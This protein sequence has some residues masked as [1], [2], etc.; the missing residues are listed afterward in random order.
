[1]INKKVVIILAGLFLAMFFANFVSAWPPFD[2][3]TNDVQVIKTTALDNHTIVMTWCDA[4]QNDI[5]FKVY[6][7][8]GTN[9]TGEIDADTSSGGCAVH[10]SQLSVSAFNE[11]TFVIG[12]FDVQDQDAT[13]HTYNR[14]GTE[15][16]S[17][18]IDVDTDVG[19]R[20][21]IS[22]SAF[23]ETAF[24]MSWRDTA[25]L[26]TGANISYG[27]YDIN[28]NTITPQT[29]IANEVGAYYTYTVSVSAFNET[30]FVVSWLNTSGATSPDL[31]F[32]TYDVAGNAIANNI[33]VTGSINGNSYS[34]GISAFNDTAFV[35]GWYD[36]SP[37]DVTFR[38]YDINGNAISSEIDADTAV[39]SVSGL[40]MSVSAIN[41]TAFAISWY[42][43]ID[44]DYTFALYDVNGNEL[45]SAI[46]AETSVTAT[47]QFAVGISSYQAATGIGLYNN[48]FIMGWG[49]SDSEAK[50]S[51]FKSKNGA[52]WNGDCLVDSPDILNAQVND[53]TK[54]QPNTI[55][56][57][58]AT[59][60]AGDNPLNTVWLEVIP[61]VSVPYNTT[62][63]NS[64]SEYFNDS[65]VLDE[66]GTWTFKFYVNDTSGNEAGPVIATDLAGNT[67]IETSTNI[68]F[69]SDDVDAMDAVALDNDIF[70]NAWCDETDNNVYFA[71]YYLNGSI[72]KSSTSAGSSSNCASYDSE[73]SITAL[74]STAFVVAWSDYSAK[75]ITF[76]AFDINGNSLYTEIDAHQD[77]GWYGG[78]SVSAF[79]ST[80]IV[81]GWFDNNLDDISFRT[82]T[83]NGTE[84][85]NQIDVDTDVGSAYSVSV[86]AF[87]S[88]TFVISWFDETDDDVTFAIY[89]INGNNLVA[90]IDADDGAGSSSRSVSVSAF[91]E[92]TFVIGWYARN[93]QDITF[94]I[95]DSSGNNLTDAIDA[96]TGVNYNSMGVSVSAINSTA[97]VISWFDGID[98]DYTFALY[99]VNGNELVSAIDA[100]ESVTA[101]TYFPQQVV[102]YQAATGIGLCQD[103]FVMG[104][105]TTDSAAYWQSYY[106]NG[107]IL[108][109]TFSCAD[110]TS[111][112][113]TINFPA[114][115]TYA[116]S[117]LPL[118]FNV[119]LSENGSV[120][121]SLNDG[122]NNFTMT[123]NEG[124]IFGTEFNATNS[125][126]ADGSYTFSVYANDT[127]GNRNYTESVTFSID[128]TPPEVTINL[129][130]ATTYNSS[131]ITFNITLNEAG[132][133]EYSLNA[134]TAN[135]TMT[136]N[137]NVDFNHTNSSIADGSYTMNAYCNDSI[138][139]T[140]YTETVAFNIDITPPAISNII[141][142]P[143]SS[144]DLD[145]NTILTFNATI[146]DPTS[147]VSA[148]FLQ[149]H[150][151]TSW[152]NATMTN[153]SAT[154]Y[155]TTITLI[156]V[157]ANY[158]FN[159]WAN[160]SLGNSNSSTNQTFTSVWDC[161][162]DII[163]S[164]GTNTLGSVSG[165]DINKYIGNVTLI[166]TGDSAYSNNNCSLVFRFSHD[167]ANDKIYFDG[168]NFNPSNTYTLAV[169]VNQTVVVNTSFSSPSS[170]TEESAIIK[171]DEYYDRSVT[172]EI[173]ITATIVTSQSGP[174]L[175]QEIISF[176]TTVYLTNGN[177]SLEGYLKNIMGDPLVI[178]ENNTAY[179]ATT[180]WEIP[181]GFTNI[182]GNLILN[183]TNISD[184]SPRYNNI[185]LSFS[186]LADATRGTK[187]FYLASYGYNISGAL[188][189]NAA[190]L[191]NLS[192]SINITFI[193]YNVS[194]SV[195]VTDCGSLD[196]D[197]VTPTT[198]VTTTTGGSGGGSGGRGASPEVVKSSADFQ[199]VRGEENEVTITFENK[200]L[201]MTLEDIEFSVEGDIAKYIQLVPKTLSALGPKGK[202]NILLKI[203]SPSYA[204]L[205]DNELVVAMKG[206]LG[207]RSYT[208]KKTIVL[209]IHE[210]SQQDAQELLDKTRKLIE[211][212]NLE[213]TCKNEVRCS[214]FLPAKTLETL[215]DLLSKSEKAMEIFDYETVRD[216]YIEIEK[217][218]SDAL[219]A[220][221]AISELATLIAQ[222]DERGIDVSGSGRILQL[223]IL[224]FQRGEFKQSLLR[225]KEAQT[226]YALEVKGEFGKLSYYLKNNKKE[227]SFVS[228]FLALLSFTTY[229]VTKL[230]MIKNKIKRLMREEKVLSEL[231]KVVQND[232]FKGKKMSME[233]YQESILQYEKRLSQVIESLIGLEIQRVYALGLTS[234]TKK[235]GKEKE[236]IIE[237]IKQVQKEYLQQGKIETRSYELRLNS[238]NRRL[239]EIDQKVA[240]LEAKNA[241]K[242]GKYF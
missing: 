33:K 232:T 4:T 211:S 64:G 111:P 165:Y 158:T 9:L 32:S 45:V 81:V 7:L 96:D 188:I 183:F 128:T 227:I 83:W 57:V 97:F 124:G 115:I 224:S 231:I 170:P 54:V 178:N 126:I 169:G 118:N 91:N 238:Y 70:V 106:P 219:E 172:S 198:T 73:V 17:A 48:N 161:T 145:P 44:G 153:S 50:W 23:N 217:T 241:I 132:Y 136:N 187:T 225:V 148:V 121:Y 38:T 202:F 99:D 47:G 105:A 56:K 102:S 86:S 5:S 21:G 49:S 14:D 131:S 42:D 210:L 8:N 228:I 107:T 103:N 204:K 220:S 62:L 135:V 214:P 196:G 68:K 207:T 193:C 206:L 163:A 171:L 16:T 85:S 140:N 109:P 100:E 90:A 63:E 11:T 51:G 184:N 138:G 40:P 190:G 101:V 234:Q 166:N 28:G 59:V 151:G 78:V 122:I 233:E 58:N 36:K 76:E 19:T 192:N 201:N 110:E 13:F 174:Y 41:S 133:C 213:L 176:P 147:S 160:D 208:D 189:E 6:D 34:I 162:W 26:D 55:V 137:G 212:Y 104:W 74:N 46:D 108:P 182:S 113:V 75:D 149:Y 173:N 2:F 152:V 180:F 222:A 157:N 146:N 116:S 141:Y 10:N 20:S 134:G 12:F 123:G 240:T 215:R 129:P 168:S 230:Q 52:L 92:T 112:T 15:I 154:N 22:V 164:G 175:T 194:D 60:T 119:T 181:S 199:L 159:V 195:Y 53:T 87:N 31:T 120:Q 79:N 72:V 127:S 71:I 177:F 80:A 89:D 209:R 150:N 155:N 77:I 25:T 82:Y 95:Y 88:T 39:G 35:V 114:N 216:N 125:S 117:D 197:Y 186:S 235:L 84:I 185:D 167:L 37:Q 236:K 24:V 29:D 156:S 98:N 69:S 65:L 3:S 144:T 18:E 191:T 239:G 93:F 43:G 221:K 203:T 139:N 223:S 67:Y 229:K 94:K 27:I 143:N 179:N 226:T 130:Q 218:V 205:G 61:P 1:M 142:S 30:A 200:N 66:L 242:R 237:L